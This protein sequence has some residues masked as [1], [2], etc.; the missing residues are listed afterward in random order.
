M[1]TRAGWV[2]MDQPGGGYSPQTW[3]RGWVLTPPRT[4]DKGLGSPPST[5]TQWQLLHVRSACVRYVPYW[6][7]FLYITAT[8]SKRRLKHFFLQ[9][10]LVMQKGHCPMYFSFS[11]SILN[12]ICCNCCSFREKSMYVMSSP[13][14]NR[15]IVVNLPQLGD[16]GSISNAPGHSSELPFTLALTRLCQVV[17]KLCKC[18]SS[19]VSA[20]FILD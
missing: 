14:K 4:W 17:C 12:R 9:R 2:D 8:D 6:N 7:A 11:A 13:T 20:C 18:R 1:F 5:D 15:E 19:V 16:I 3:D 10:L